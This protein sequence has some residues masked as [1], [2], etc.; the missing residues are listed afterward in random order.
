[1]ILPGEI[2]LADFD[3]MVRTSSAFDCPSG[4]ESARR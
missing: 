1:M 3:E 2:Y 4:G